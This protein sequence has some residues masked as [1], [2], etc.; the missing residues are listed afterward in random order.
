MTGLDGVERK[1]TRTG[2]PFLT[3]QVASVPPAQPAAAGHPGSTHPEL[4]ET[5]QPRRGFWLRVQQQGS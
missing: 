2:V 1:D 4:G 5:H 3:P